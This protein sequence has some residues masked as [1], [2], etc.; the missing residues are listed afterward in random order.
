MRIEMDKADQKARSVKQINE[1]VHDGAL[2][3]IERFMSDHLGANKQIDK[4]T[5][6]LDDLTTKNLTLGEQVE[7]VGKRI[8]KLE[9]VSGIT[10]A[11]VARLRGDTNKSAEDLVRSIKD[12]VRSMESLNR[13]L[14]CILAVFIATMI[15][16]GVIFCRSLM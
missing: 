14:N 4:M 8:G 11:A 7:K 3:R 13:K 1:F 6:T 9:D 5:I 12:I 2:Q 15:M 10:R 16:V